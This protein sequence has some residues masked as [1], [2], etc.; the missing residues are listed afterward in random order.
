MSRIILIG[1]RGTGKSTVGPL[2]TE[3][4]G[5]SFIDADV[6]LE[7]DSGLSVADIFASEG[8]EGF[9]EREMTL[10]I[11]LLQRENLVLATGGGVILR[12]ENRTLMQ[13]SGFVVWLQA[14]APTIWQ[15]IQAD[16]TTVK[17]RPR[18]TSRHGL[19]EVVHLLALRE[20]LY[21][22]TAHFELNTEE[23]SPSELVATIVEAWT[24]YCNSR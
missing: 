13:E 5:W 20:P 23:M 17:R 3:R 15:R 4:L 1:Y 7:S 8:E 22:Q 19:D 16:P 21:R 10:L 2:L 11:E 12:P 9:R 14:S 6:Q 18:L 24:S